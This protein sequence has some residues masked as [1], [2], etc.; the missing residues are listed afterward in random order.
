MLPKRFSVSGR[1]ALAKLLAGTEVQ[2]MLAKAVGVGMCSEVAQG[3]PILLL[4]LLLLLDEE[5]DEPDWEEVD[6][7]EMLT[8]VAV[9]VMDAADV[10]DEWLDADELVE[11][12]V[13]DDVGAE[14]GLVVDARVPVAS[15]RAPHTL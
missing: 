1:V 9:E 4:L 7:L 15:S 8:V 2:A 11:L 12:T 3:R 10:P 6:L 14:D 13:A 5:L